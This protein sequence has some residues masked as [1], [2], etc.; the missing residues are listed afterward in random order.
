M[1]S[2]THSITQ[3]YCHVEY[4]ESLPKG[5]KPIAAKNGKH[6]ILSYMPL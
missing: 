5:L 6:P 1:Q 2:F 3:N 4:I